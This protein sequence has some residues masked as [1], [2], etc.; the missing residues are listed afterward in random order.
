MSPRSRL[1]FFL[2]RFEEPSALRPGLPAAVE[3]LVLAMLSRRPP[4]RPSAA[5]ALEECHRLV[6]SLKEGEEKK[7]LAEINQRMANPHLKPPALPP[8][9][10]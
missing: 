5:E 9:L 8:D 2:D 4:Q 10:R 6:R 1:P 3:K 7:R